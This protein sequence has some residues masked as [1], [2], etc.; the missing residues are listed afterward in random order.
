MKKWIALLLGLVLAA[1]GICLFLSRTWM[2][3]DVPRVGCRHS[4]HAMSG[5][6]CLCSSVTCPSAISVFALFA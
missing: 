5:I 1:A 4:C 3:A 2:W 6:I